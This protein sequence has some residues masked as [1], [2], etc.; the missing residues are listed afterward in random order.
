MATIFAAE[1][2]FDVPFYQ[3]K[4][5]HTITDENVKDFWARHDDL[6]K[7]RGCYVFGIRAGKGLTPS[8]VGSR[9]N[10]VT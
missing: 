5:G 1:G 6:G 10:H 8:Y 2:P 4:A 7:Q 3:G 9:F